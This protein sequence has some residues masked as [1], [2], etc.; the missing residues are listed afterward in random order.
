MKSKCAAII[1]KTVYEETSV[2][3]FIVLLYNCSQHI[4]CSPIHISQMGSHAVLHEQLPPAIMQ[5]H[6]YF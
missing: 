6:S 3:H 5:L 4:L 2:S 1:F